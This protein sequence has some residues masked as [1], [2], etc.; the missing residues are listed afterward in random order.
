MKLSRKPAGQTNE[1]SLVFYTT[2]YALIQKEIA[3]LDEEFVTCEK[4]HEVKDTN[5]NGLFVTKSVRCKDL[6]DYR[7]QSCTNNA[8]VYK[9]KRKLK[10][11]SSKVTP[12]IIMHS[13]IDSIHACKKL[14][15]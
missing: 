12:L 15:E 8:E 4:Y 11:M 5:D 2:K 10:A 9:K 3:R 7:C 13:R 6:G 1:E 14:G